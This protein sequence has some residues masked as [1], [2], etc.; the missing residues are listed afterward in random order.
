[1][2]P[3]LEI[4]GAVVVRAQGRRRATIAVDGGRIVGLFDAPSGAATRLIDADG[5]LA[6]PGM[7]DEHVHF[8]GPGCEG[9]ETGSAAAVVG[10]VTCVAEHHHQAPVRTPAE[11]TAKADAVAGRSHA[12]F[13]LGAHAS[14]AAPELCGPLRDAGCAFVKAFTCTTHGITGF[15]SDDLLRLFNAA[16]AAGLRVLVHCEDEAITAAAEERLRRQDRTDNALLNEWRAPEAELVAASTVSLMARI[17]GARVTVAHVT[18]PAVADLIARERV[19]GAALDAETCPQYLLLDSEE[20]GELG[21]LRKFTPPARPAPAAAGLW[22]RL[23]NGTVSILA[24]DHAP[25]TL[26]EKAGGDI[27]SA[28]FGLPGIE[29]TLPLALD[30]ALRGRLELERLVE[31][32]ALAPARALGLAPAKGSLEPGA[33]ADIVLVDP[34]ARRTLTNNELVS[35]AGWTPYEGRRLLGRPVTTFLRGVIAASDGEPVGHPVGEF[36]APR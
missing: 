11:L 2:S 16:A 7:V 34:A 29:T 28:P 26:Q 35:G 9:F 20:V 17:T 14:A 3:E 36:V 33:D 21:P 18:Q 13:A 12:D 5:L 31:A 4:A 10:G 15:D 25:S 23:R 30:G 6:L 27:W 8:E 24:S 19:L 22:E 1:M 32:Y